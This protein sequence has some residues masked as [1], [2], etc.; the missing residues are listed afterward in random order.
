MK[1]A[2]ITG[3]TH[4]LRGDPGM[5]EAWMEVMNEQE[6]R[7][8]IRGLVDQERARCVQI[9]QEIGL[10][11]QQEEGSYSAGKKAGALECVDALSR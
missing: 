3:L 8:A 6:I 11:H 1:Q 5:L 2:D 10:R 4:A 7:D 9:C